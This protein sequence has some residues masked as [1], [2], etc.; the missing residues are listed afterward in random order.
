MPHAYA[1]SE[2]H[3]VLTYAVKCGLKH[4]H[5]WG[6]GHNSRRT[7]NT[8]GAAKLIKYPPILAITGC[9]PAKQTMFPRQHGHY[10]TL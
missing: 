2:G 1:H 5:T 3:A 4:F 9:V 8:F 7:L 6:N 10:T